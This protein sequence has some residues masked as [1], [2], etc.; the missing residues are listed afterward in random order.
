[1]RH[2]ICCPGHRYLLE[3]KAG[4]IIGA[5][6][7]L[8]IPLLRMPTVDEI[9]I[10]AGI[11]PIE[12]EHLVYKLAAQTGWFK[13]TPELIHNPRRQLGEVLVCAAR[14]RQNFVTEDGK[15]EKFDYDEDAGIVEEA[16]RFLRDYPQLLP[17]LTDDGEKVNAWSQEAL[18]FLGDNYVPEDR[19]IPYFGV[20]SPRY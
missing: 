8:K 4:Q 6:E 10:E 13:P 2:G 14:I 12:A 11:P 20:A 18:R 7:G 15:S 17:K 5:I 19:N 1:M 9:A 16:K 3:V